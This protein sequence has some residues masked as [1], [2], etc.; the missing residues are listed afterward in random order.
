MTDEQAEEYREEAAR[1]S[2]LSVADQREVLAIYRG[3]AENPKLT[4]QRREWNRERVEALERTLKR[5]NRKK[6]SRDS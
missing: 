3:C 4:R 1:L 5:L 2:A 6:K